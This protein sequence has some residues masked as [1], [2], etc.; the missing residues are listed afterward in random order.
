MESFT[1]N[2][3]VTTCPHGFNAFKKRY[4][5]R[6]RKGVTLQHHTQFIHELIAIKKLKIKNKKEKTIKATYHDP[7]YLSKHNGLYEE[8]REILKSIPGVEIVE[9]RRSR[10]KS[11]CCGGGGGRMWADFDENKKLSE[12]RVEEA[13]V[14]GAELLVTACPFCLVNVEDSIKTM[15]V[16][17]KIRVMDIAEL[18]AEYI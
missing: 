4:P 9:M 18:V 5:E 15:D 6:L 8:P 12:V 17:G 13:L 14:T 1:T 7:C 16:E 2:R 3:I 11:I 10:E